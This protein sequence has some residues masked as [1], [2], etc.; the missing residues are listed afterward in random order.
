LPPI[1]CTTTK[2]P[3]NTGTKAYNPNH[4]KKTHLAKPAVFNGKEFKGGWR[5]VLLYILGNNIDFPNDRDKILFALSFM[6]EGLAE[7]WSQNYVDW[8]I[9]ENNEDFGMWEHFCQKIKESFENKNARQEAQGRLDN[10]FQGKW[11]AEEFFQ[12]FELLHCKAGF[13]DEEHCHEFDVFCLFLLSPLS[14][15]IL[16]L[17]YRCFIIWT[18]CYL[19]LII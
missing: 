1:T 8:A 3:Q 6:T 16:F 17:S 12:Q 19:V 10:L 2:P 15:L 11:T 5:T 4:R 9:G 13:T 7:K 18:L 14:H